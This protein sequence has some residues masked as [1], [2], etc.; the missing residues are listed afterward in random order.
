MPAA[1]RRGEIILLQA[2]ALEQLA[3]G[4]AEAGLAT[5]R[6]AAETERAIPAEYG[7]PLVEKPSFELLGD[8]LARI[9]RREEA[10]QAYASALALAPGRRLAT[11]GVAA[12]AVAAR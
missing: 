4:E 3:T 7:P 9:G 2:R 10:R 8:V 12:D 5:L 11:Q 6:Q 1:V